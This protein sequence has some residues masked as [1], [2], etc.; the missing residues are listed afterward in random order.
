MDKSRVS[1]FSLISQSIYG[2]DVEEIRAQT[3]MAVM[4][5]Q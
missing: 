3:N 5:S 1:C 4:L 2:V